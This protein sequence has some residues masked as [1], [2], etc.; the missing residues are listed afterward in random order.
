MNSEPEIPRPKVTVITP[1]YNN[2][3]MIG[4]CLDSL[5][6][7][8]YPNYEVIV[9]D[10]GS[11]DNTPEEVL[12]YP[13]LLIRN[14]HLGI[15]AA[16]NTAVRAAAGEIIMTM[17][18]DLKVPGDL[19]GRMVEGLLADERR[20]VV[21]AWWDI[22]NPD[23]LIPALIFRGYEYFVRQ[24]EEPNFFWGYCFAI[25]KKIFDEIGYFDE[26]L[27][28]VEDVDFS[29][30]MIEAGY[31]VKIL[32][33]VRVWHY[34]RDSLRAHLSRHLRT[35]RHKFL[36]VRRSKRFI[37]ERGTATEYVKLILH[38]LTLLSVLALPWYPLVFA[39]LLALS[40]LSHLPM[41]VWSMKKGFK[42]ILMMPFE[43][44]T[45]AAWALGVIQ[46][47]FW[48]LRGYNPSPK[49]L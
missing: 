27:P 41:T 39:I 6:P 26:T 32:K 45:K 15:S 37:D 12:K 33:D 14:P 43:F 18:S 47:M 17:D 28:L 4:E 42:Y 3:R 38:L 40:L 7:Q 48:L 23:N 19:I 10:D 9:V 22:S 25:R 36:Y 1:I 34:F 2:A 8:D 20:G 35:A 44:L 11:T 49:D 31:T 29:Y 30:R 16:R 21:M 46:G 13:V 5:L 24:L